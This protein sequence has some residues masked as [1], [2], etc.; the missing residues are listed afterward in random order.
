MFKWTGMRVRTYDAT[1]RYLQRLGSGVC[2]LFLGV[3]I[4][5]SWG[6]VAFI[7]GGFAAMVGLMLIWVADRR[8]KAT[9][10]TTAELSLK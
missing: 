1:G 6:P 4:A 9:D 7:F 8:A 3:E 5:R 2:G 10:G